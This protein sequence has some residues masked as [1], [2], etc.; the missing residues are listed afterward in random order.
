VAYLDDVI[1]D[2][3]ARFPVDEKRVYLIGHSNGGCMS[4]RYA[5][6]RAARVAAIVSSAG[7]MWSDVSKCRPSEPVAVLEL[8]GTRD[9]VVPYAGDRPDIRF[10]SAHESVLDWARLDGCAEA[11]DRSAAPMRLVVGPS[12]ASGA[13]TTVERWGGCRGVELWT[14]K[15][16][17]HSP[18]FLQPDLARAL[19]AWLLA[20]P[21]P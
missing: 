4:Y 13:E 16:S 7:S 6:D 9:E 18:D 11:V 5:C 15:D 21:K 14:M 1:A 20:H 2:M 3:S 19:G 12:L 10:T 8:H 17:V